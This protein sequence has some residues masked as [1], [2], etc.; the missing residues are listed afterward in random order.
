[1]YLDHLDRLDDLDYLLMRYPSSSSSKTHTA[2]R[3]GSMGA[4]GSIAVQRALEPVRVSGSTAAIV[5]AR[6]IQRARFAGRRSTHPRYAMSAPRPSGG[7]TTF[8][9]RSTYSP[10]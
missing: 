1:M 7:T 2:M 9:P 3:A 6:L 10:F 5:L 4:S 8:S